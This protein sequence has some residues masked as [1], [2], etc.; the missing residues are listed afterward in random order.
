MNT[1]I[2]DA[3]GL[4]LYILRGIYETLEH[5]IL[6]GVPLLYILIGFTVVGLTVRYIFGGTV[7]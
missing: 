1:A 6:F 5:M 2:D 3:W 7:K 4:L